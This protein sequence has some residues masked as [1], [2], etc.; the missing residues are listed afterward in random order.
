MRTRRIALLFSL[1]WICALPLSAQA[2]HGRGPM[3]GEMRPGAGWERWLPLLEQNQGPWKVS[4]S[5]LKSFKEIL[6]LF[7]R[8]RVALQ[9]ENNR[10]RVDLKALLREA[11]SPEAKL[12][13]TM[14]AIS[15]NQ[16][17]IFLKGRALG[18]KV[19]ALFTPEQKEMI[20]QALEPKAKA[21][22][23]WRQGGPVP[24][25]GGEGERPPHPFDGGGPGEPEHEE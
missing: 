12:L 25:K 18:K 23:E 3:G 21:P 13:A 1:L 16:H 24:P 20:R 15:H 4:D 22:R 8:E 17:L 2:L 7:E 10:L 11:D 5:Q 14:D 6:G 9:N 19:E